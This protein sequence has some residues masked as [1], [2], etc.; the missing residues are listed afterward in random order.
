MGLGEFSSA[1]MRRVRRALNCKQHNG[2]DYPDNAATAAAGKFLYCSQV[3]Q[4]WRHIFIKE[5][6]YSLFKPER[7][8]K[9][10]PTCSD[11]SKGS[12]IRDP[13]RGNISMAYVFV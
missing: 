4:N 7:R 1:L 6:G 8:K 10:F 11:N 9:S 3:M 13:K 5:S 2:T 12:K